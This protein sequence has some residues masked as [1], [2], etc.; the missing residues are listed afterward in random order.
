MADQGRTAGDIATRFDV[1]RQA[2]SQH[3]RILREAGLIGERREGTRRWCGQ[4]GSRRS[5]PTSRR[6]GRTHWPPEGGRR[7]RARIQGARCRAQLSRCATEVLIAAPPGSASRPT[8][9]TS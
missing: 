7:A 2:I 1:T 3:L 4:R 5:A 8:A 6:C 9:A